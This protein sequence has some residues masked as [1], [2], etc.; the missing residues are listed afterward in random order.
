M[1]NGILPPAARVASALAF[2]LG[3]IGA[4]EY[5]RRR[6]GEAE[7]SAT[8]YLPSVFAGA[9]LVSLFGAVLSAQMLYG[10]IGGTSGMIS[11]IVVAGIAMVLWA[12]AGCNRC[13]WRVLCAIGFGWQ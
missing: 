10:L 3:L 11:M 5:I 12:I 1:E 4:G 8:A 13:Y 6:C 2:G 7:D 9:G